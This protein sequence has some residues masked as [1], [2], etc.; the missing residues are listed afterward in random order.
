MKCATGTLGGVPEPKIEDSTPEFVHLNDSVT[1]RLEAVVGY[2][3]TDTRLRVHFDAGGEIDIMRDQGPR[4][5]KAILDYWL[6]GG[7]D[8]DGV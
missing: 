2:K 3:L 4:K 6:A 5:A 7:N 8:H 1:V